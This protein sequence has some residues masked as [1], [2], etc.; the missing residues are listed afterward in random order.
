MKGMRKQYDTI[1]LNG[2]SDIVRNITEAINI[3]TKERFGRATSRPLDNS[4]ATVVS[5]NTTAK[6]F[7]MVKGMIE[8]SY[9]N[10]CIFYE[11]IE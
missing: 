1:I 6:N 10:M 3:V 7:K 8:Q 11:R 9:P 5:I 4:N 2:S